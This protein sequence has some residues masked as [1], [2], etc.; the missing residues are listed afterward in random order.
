MYDSNEIL[1]HRLCDMENNPDCSFQ[2]FQFPGR[3]YLHGL[4]GG[5]IIP[6]EIELLG[7]HPGDNVLETFWNKK[8]YQN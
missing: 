8:R 2:I 4:R 6:D 5:N 3:I 7:R 1:T